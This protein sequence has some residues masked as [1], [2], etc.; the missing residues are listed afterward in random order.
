M[1]AVTGGIGLVLG[2]VLNCVIGWLAWWWMAH[3]MRA[4]PTV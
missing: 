3:A 1:V 4:R 2:I